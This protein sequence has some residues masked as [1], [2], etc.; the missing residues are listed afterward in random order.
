VSVVWV[1][2]DGVGV[3]PDDPDINPWA[4]ID[5]PTLIAVEG[6]L[7]T[8]P[9]A[10]H[11]P[12]DASL[13]VKG[14]P[15]SATGTTALFTGVNAPAKLG[16]HLS[17]FPIPKLLD[18]IAEESVHKKAL[19]RGLKTTF[20]NAFNEAY[21]KRPETR[22]S[23]TTHAVKAA[24]IPFRMMDDYRAGRAVFH[25]LTGELIRIQGND[26]KLVPPGE[27]KQVVFKRF[28]RDSDTFADRMH[29]MD[30]EVIDPEEAGRRV[31]GLAADF[32]LV[33]F[34]YVKTDMAGHNQEQ[35]W[36]KDVADGL[37]IQ[38]LGGVGSQ[39]LVEHSGGHATQCDLFGV[40]LALEQVGAAG[41]TRDLARHGKAG[42]S[43]HK[44][45]RNSHSN[46]V[47]NLAMVLCLHSHSQ[48]TARRRAFRS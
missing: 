42:R 14:L 46:T 25:D 18:I 7:P 36:A 10:V 4:A 43:D 27:S 1:F 33:I 28:V 12:L 45:Q 48:N 11:V 17:G 37:V 26:D 34:E 15:Q 39:H 35:G 8:W 32:D 9:G 23:V 20:A 3:G 24:G 47:P 29:E 21:F 16:R 31:G 19:A 40:E 6:R 13:G 44:D 2:L 41:L 22:Q 38:C 30:L 5:D